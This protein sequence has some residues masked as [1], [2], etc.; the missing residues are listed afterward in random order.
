MLPVEQLRRRREHTLRYRSLFVPW[1]SVTHCTVLVVDFHARNK[2]LLVWQNRRILGNL[3]VHAG[4][5]RQCRQFF[6]KGIGPAEVA[7]G[8]HPETR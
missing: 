8:A 5:Q 1:Q 2:I 4:V 3:M 7:T 6:S